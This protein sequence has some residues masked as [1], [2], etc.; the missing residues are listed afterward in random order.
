MPPQRQAST[1]AVLTIPNALSFARI[2]TI[3]AIVWALVHRGTEAAGLVAFGV[4]ASTDWI[5]GYVAR[6][7]HRVSEL[8]KLLD[9][10]AD[11]LAIVAVLVAL[12]VRDAFPLLAAAL[13][14]VRDLAL[15]LVGAVA[16][17]TRDIR[18][19]V[20]TI[21]KAATLTLMVA[22]P[23]IAWGAFDLWPA[24]AATIF[25]WIGFAVGIVLSYAAAGRYAIDLRRAL[26]ARRRTGG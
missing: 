17:A 5:D 22:V 18:I 24:T 2:A 20:R 21:G 14:V 26:E 15:V 23:S 25:G 8:G 12:V 1:S 19:E 3:P 10:L 9:P 4:I 11:R 13:I 7:T 6:R 16:L